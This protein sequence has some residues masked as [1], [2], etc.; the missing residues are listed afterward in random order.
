MLYPDPPSH[1]L[2]PVCAMPD[3]QPDSPLFLPSLW[4]Q[5][6]EPSSP[7]CF[8]KGCQRL[9]PTQ[10]SEKAAKEWGG[11]EHSPFIPALG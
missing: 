6:L 9:D 1:V 2:P 7:C 10:M 4:N 11:L 5:H 3:W 8:P